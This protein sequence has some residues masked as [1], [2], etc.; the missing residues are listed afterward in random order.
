[1]SRIAEVAYEVVAKKW[2]PYDEKHGYCMRLVRQIVQRALGLSYDEFKAR[3]WTH[4]VE[5]NLTGI[6]WARTMQLSLREAGGCAVAFEDRQ[7]GDLLFTWELALQGHTGVL[8]DRRQL[9]ENT[10]SSRGLHI[11]GFNRFSPLED[12]PANPESIEIFRL[13]Q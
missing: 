8:Y 11:S 6:P 5:D 7:A 9:I 4:E 1:M 2:V 13:E 3:Y 12:F 10:G